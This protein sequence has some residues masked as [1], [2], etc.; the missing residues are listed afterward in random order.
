MLTLISGGT[1]S[2]KSTLA[3]EMAIKSKK[4]VVFCA[5]AEALDEEM[6]ERIALHQE[7]RPKE[8]ELLEEPM[9][10][11][12][13]LRDIESDKLVIIDCLTMYISNLLGVGYTDEE[14]S[15]AV[16]DLLEMIGKRKIETIV[17]SNE[18]G[19]GIV[20]NNELAR[21]FRDLTGKVNQEIASIADQVFVCF[22]GFPLKL[23]P[24]VVR[25]VSTG[26]A[27]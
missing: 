10:L 16:K 12:K 21:R 2:G 4:H 19:M 23:K 26:F 9:Q 3:V 11:A 27:T 7:N 25:P 15:E 6:E 24:Q 8:W 1:R 13:V 18:V 17:V 22:L 20:P 5:T 14:I